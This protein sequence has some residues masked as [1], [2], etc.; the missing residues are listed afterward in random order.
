MKTLIAV[1]LVLFLV[2]CSGGNFNPPNPS[3]ITLQ[4]AAG[5]TVND[6]S[7]G[8]RNQWLFAGGSQAA[9]V[10][11]NGLPAS[12]QYLKTSS[13]DVNLP[14]HQKDD[15][16]VSGIQV[17]IQRHKYE[18]PLATSQVVNDLTLT[19]LK[20]TQISEDKANTTL[21]WSDTSSVATYGGP[22]DTWGLAWTP[23]EISELSVR[24]SV[25]CASNNV[26]ADVDSVKVTVFYTKK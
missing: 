22:T 5:T 13:F 9:T 12:S 25:I 10:Y 17:D 8:S 11:S 7:N 24:L 2:S 19:L 14:F 16:V 15:Y 20:G 3:S 26:S 4:S 23:E 6:G 21:N 1:V 18:N